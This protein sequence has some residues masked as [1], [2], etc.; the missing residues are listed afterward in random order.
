M[1]HQRIMVSGKPHDN[2]STFTTVN[3]RLFVLLFG[4]FLSLMWFSLPPHLQVLC[5]SAYS[6]AQQVLAHKGVFLCKQWQGFLSQGEVPLWS[7]CTKIHFSPSPSVSTMLLH[8][9][10]DFRTKLR[11]NFDTVRE[12]RLKAT[13]KE[14]AET[15]LYAEGY[16]SFAS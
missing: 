3:S 12:C 10:A 2:S 1:D 4:C 5:E 11:E 15:F 14:S 8:D 6:L 13:R 7:I 16:H 9:L